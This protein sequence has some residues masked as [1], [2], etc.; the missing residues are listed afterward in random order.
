MFGWAKGI[1]SVKH[2]CVDIAMGIPADV[3]GPHPRTFLI[4][5]DH[6]L[7]ALLS[8]EDT[9]DDYR[10]TIDDKGP[11]L[12][13]LRTV[14]FRRPYQMRGTYA[15]SNLLQE[16]TTAKDHG[17]KYFVLEE[18]RLNEPP[19]MRLK[20]LIRDCFWASLTRRIDWPNIER[21]A[22]DPKDWTEGRA[23]RL[24]IPRGAKNELDYYMEHATAHFARP[25]DIQVLPDL[26][27]INPSDLRSLMKKPGLLALEMESCICPESG[28]RSICG[29]PYVVPGGRFNELYGWDSYFIC[30]GLLTSGQIDLAV[31]M[32]EQL[33]FCIEHY[34]KVLNANRSYY[35]G[36]SQPPF[37]TDLALKVY[38]RIAHLP[39]A[40]AFLKRA[41]LCAIKEYYQVWL[42]EP[43][44]DPGTGLSRYRPLAAGIPLETEPGHFAHVLS[45]LSEKHG[46]SCEAFIQAYNNGDIY[47]PALDE[48][49]AHDQGVR[50]SGHDTTYRLDRRCANLV[51]VDLNSLLY[52]YE[53]DISYAI[54]TVFN[55]QLK[56]GETS[57]TA[58]THGGVIETSGVWSRR[59]ERRKQAMSYY[60]WDDQAG[61]FFDYDIVA[62][63]RSTY[64]SATAFWPM[65]AGLSTNLQ[66]SHLVRYGLPRLE[67]M[68]GLAAGSEQSRGD[69][70]ADRP[71]KQWDFPYGWAPHQMLAW[72]G[73]LQYGCPAEAQRLVYKWLHM[74]VRTFKDFGGAVVEK[75]NVTDPSHPH[76]VSAEYG[77][78]GLNFQGRPLEGFGWVNAS[79]LVG[80][81]LLPERLH[82]AL[83]MC[84][85]YDELITP[86][87]SSVND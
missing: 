84:V 23:L 30:L 86:L 39:S 70:G 38:H 36:R 5:T 33:C 57:Q 55:N 58:S 85:P 24:Y 69:I 79:F 34:G 49:L 65:W 3:F 74:I 7:S 44:Y 67:M 2:V 26:A 37:L 51:T 25:L 48:Y 50:E 83:G 28:I 17:C 82:Q 54:Q 59:A 14:A 42:A 8:A 6:T 13:L 72:E 52:K 71:E 19:V 4:D 87:N 46:M 40:T 66:A 56:L 15:L 20:R 45:P 11:K 12:F 63:Q 81:D 73:L 32:T 47:E 18:D 9:D 27:N 29:K 61:M 78:Q 60:L 35:L 75:Y 80:L 62:K 53:V 76:K 22:E 41:I 10:I 21:V 64:E 77:N 43:R 31:S 68:G 1:L 16:L